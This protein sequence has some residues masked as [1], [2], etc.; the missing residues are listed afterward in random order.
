MNEAIIPGVDA[1]AVAAARDR[2]AQLTKPPGSL[3]R[4][5]DVVIRLAG[6]QGRTCPQL[7]QPAI[8]IFAADHGV[9]AE[10]VSAFPQAVTG[11]MLANF[12]AGGAAINAV[13]RHIEAHLEVV[14]VG[15][16]APEDDLPGVRCERAGA[17]TAN[18][19]AEP[20][21][22][23]P[24]FEQAY[25]SGTEAAQRARDAGADCYIP[26][27]MGIGNTTAAT[28]VACALLNRSPEAVVG[29]GT[30]LDAQGVRH[31]ASV[32]ARALTHHAAALN[33]PAAIVQHIGGYEL[34]A[35]MGA[36]TR[37]AELGMPVLLDGFIA[38]TAA[39]AAVRRT[40][41]VAPWLIAAH[42]SAE[43]GHAILL[44]ELG[45]TPLLDL[46]MRLGEASGAATTVPLIR[47]ACAIHGEMATF[48]SAGIATENDIG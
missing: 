27:E 39:L 41:A 26:G 29:A 46:G 34:A 31:K 38:T 28:A 22:T 18:F 2:Q 24:A 32:I 35:M 45:E 19:V 9:T 17:G 42:Q 44:G 3:G 37:A 8:S 6:L 30:G 36:Y 12:A 40:P 21:M 47:T 43:A 33:T 16:L 15:T 14:D 5:E 25:V 20:A 48:E 11:Q 10:G 13:A 7:N 23:A 4:L 1:T